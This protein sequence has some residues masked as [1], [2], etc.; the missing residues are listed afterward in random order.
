MNVFG[1][2]IP[3]EGPVFAVTIGVHIAAGLTAVAAGA[4]AA[5][6]RKRHG[7]HPRA[8]RVY[9]GALAVVFATATVLAAIRWRQDR[10]LF[11]IAAVAFA[12]A[13][14]GWWL[15]RRR[16]ARW[17]VWH[18]TSMSGSYVALLTGFYVDNGPHLPVWD[19][20]PH[21]A[22]WLLPAL[23]GIPLTWWA[24]KRNGALT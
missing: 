5:T 10:Q 19:R 2:V 21:L 22:Y 23:V 12:L 6:A 14:T 18:G 24:L 11:T 17:L 9:L 13:L 7:R 8:G 16:P 1:I 3:D 20:L 15:R 4:L